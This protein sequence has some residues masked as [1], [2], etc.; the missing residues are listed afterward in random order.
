MKQKVLFCILA[1][2]LLTLAACKKEEAKN[3][4]ALPADYDLAAAIKDLPVA[5]DG[6][7]LP[8]PRVC[9]SEEVKEEISRDEQGR[10]LTL[11]DAIKATDKDAVVRFLTND[12]VDP[13]QK[14]KSGEPLLNMAVRHGFVFAVEQLLKAGVN[15]KETDKWGRT[16]LMELYQEDGVLSEENDVD[17]LDLLLKAGVDI[18]AHMADA[19]ITA[20]QQAS[21]VGSAEDVKK[22]LAA[23]ADV[24]AEDGE[25]NNALVWACVGM[26]SQADY[27][28]ENKNK[29]VQILLTAGANQKEHAWIAAIDSGFPITA[30][31]LWDSGIDINEKTGLELLLAASRSGMLEMVKILLATGV[32]INTTDQYGRTALALATSPCGTGICDDKIGVVKALLAAGADVNQAATSLNALVGNVEVMKILLSAGADVNEKEDDG[33]TMLMA[34]VQGEEFDMVK[35]LLSSG[36]EVNVQD[37][38]GKTALNIAQETGNEEI[39]KLLKSAGAKEGIVKSKAETEPWTPKKLTQAEFMDQ[40]FL[41]AAQ[42]GDYETVKNL[43]DMNVDINTIDKDGNTA[44]KLAQKAGNKKIVELLK[45]A[46]AEE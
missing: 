23:G 8:E 15:I 5:S 3:I 22:L 9:P 12:K 11:E 36:A 6:E 16:A 33:T 14:T 1:T 29:V 17:I 34:A 35:L 46:G 28:D 41:E 27:D 45:Q 13:N 31:T 30:K 21:W 7:A 10:P 25:G 38:N 44:L 4:V 37:E 20:L 43:I 40:Q 18:N 2:V 39:I 26:D 19:G 42:K 24:N 32:D